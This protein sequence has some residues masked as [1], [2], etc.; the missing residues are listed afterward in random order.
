[1]MKILGAVLVLVFALMLP[2]VAVAAERSQPPQAASNAVSQPLGADYSSLGSGWSDTWSYGGVVTRREGTSTFV[3]TTAYAGFYTGTSKSVIKTDGIESVTF[4]ASGDGLSKVTP[5]LVSSGSKIYAAND[6]STYISSQD[7]EWVKYVIPIA[8]F[9][10]IVDIGGIKL[11]ATSPSILAPFTVRSVSVDRVS[12]KGSVSAARPLYS[13]P[14]VE[15]AAAQRRLMASGSVDKAKSL[16][17]IV[18]SPTAVWL[19]NWVAS[20][21]N[22]TAALI[23]SAKAADAVPQIVLYNIPLRDCSGRGPVGKNR[24]D[25][26]RA[27]VDEVRAGMGDTE[28]IVLIEPDALSHIPACLSSAGATERIAMIAY[29]ASVMQA[30][31]S[32]VYV[33]AGNSA[34]LPSSTIASLLEKVGVGGSIGFSLNVSNYRPTESEALYGNAISALLPGSP[35]FV[36]DVSRNG[37]AVDPAV[38]C[39]ATSARLGVAPTLTS[40]ID[41]VDGLLWI[42]RPGES[43]GTCNSGPAP[44]AF[45]VAGALTLSAGQ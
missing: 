25:Q 9:G 44:G 17:R 5:R 24:S 20:A 36:I 41:H 34:W 35:N 28:A 15:A 23:A 21:Q 4:I 37:A 8:E 1:M 19:G 40:G 27:W 22:T 26:Y 39:N 13:A 11:Q 14:N 7:G 45:W 3:A 12:D 18:N 43:D 33:D 29:A 38:W 16:S 6:L 2:D 30:Q 32:R 42:K 10:E 31:G